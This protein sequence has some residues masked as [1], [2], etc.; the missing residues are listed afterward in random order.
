MDSKQLLCDIKELSPLF[1]ESNS[2]E[3]LLDKA[4]E[5]VAARTQSAVCSIY[6][7]NPEDRMLTLRASRGLNPASVG[8]VR[9]ELGQGLTGLALQEMKASICRRR[10]MTSRI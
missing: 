9:L 4:V 2:I 10:P 6:L 1:R 5:M 7:Y 8:Q 3:I